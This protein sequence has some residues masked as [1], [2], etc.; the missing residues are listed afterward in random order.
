MIPRSS[1]IARTPSIV[2]VF[3]VDP[4][5]NRCFLFKVI[6]VLTFPHNCYKL[7]CVK[8]VTQ[9]CS[10]LPIGENGSV[11]A[12]QNGIDDFPGALVV[13]VDLLRV[14]AEDD[15]ER[16]LFRWFVTSAICRILHADTAPNRVHIYGLV[17]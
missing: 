8:L 14:G 5:S 11:I 13:N 2:N 15:V 16:K 17:T 3:P 6:I 12:F 7:V 1:G 9:T 4:T 10:G